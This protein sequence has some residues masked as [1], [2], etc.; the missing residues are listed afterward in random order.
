MEK[1][2]DEIKEKRRCEID[3]ESVDVKKLLR[4]PGG[5]SKLAH[6]AIQG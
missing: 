5:V 4:Y 1:L 3:I 6:L 2:Q